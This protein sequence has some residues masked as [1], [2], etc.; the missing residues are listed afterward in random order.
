V[1]VRQD[2]LL[3][4]AAIVESEGSGF[5]RPT[6]FLYLKQDAREARG[7]SPSS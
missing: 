5:A 2:V 1:A 7:V 4:A 6:E 3:A